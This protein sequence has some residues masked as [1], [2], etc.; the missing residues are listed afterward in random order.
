MAVSVN[1]INS[2]RGNILVWFRNS[3]ATHFEKHWPNTSIH[4]CMFV[5]GCRC[6]MCVC[7]CLTD[8]D[9]CAGRHQLQTIL[10]SH[11]NFSVLGSSAV[12]AARPSPQLPLNVLLNHPNKSFPIKVDCLLV[13]GLSLVPSSS[14]NSPL[15]IP[16]HFTAYL[17]QR[18]ARCPTVAP[19][20][21]LYNMRQQDIKPNGPLTHR[22]PPGSQ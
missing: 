20:T 6:D 4:W 1:A 9:S 17:D 15:K 3:L 5:C 10:W 18:P 19:P 2:S 16:L 11:L 13:L 22:C 7:V 14:L 12:L 21:P 8:R